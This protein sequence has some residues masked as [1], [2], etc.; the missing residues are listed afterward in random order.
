[1]NNIYV[2]L[3]P[4]FTEYGI[5]I[6]DDRNKLIELFNLE[7]KIDKH[8]PST[9]LSGINKIT[10][11]LDVI[12]YRVIRDN[13]AV[14]FPSLEL[15]TTYG[16]MFQAELYA[17]DYATYDLL[18][19]YVSLDEINLYS[20]SFISSVRKTCTH[21]PHPDAEK[22]D[23]TIFMVM[24]MLEVFKKHGYTL[25][26]LDKTS[27]T[28]TGVKE[29]RRYIRKETITSGTADAF[30]LAVKEYISQNKNDLTKDILKIA[31]KLGDKGGQLK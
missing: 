11:D 25:S 17:L 15:A 26:E 14:I 12:F 4:S 7:C 29:G 20:T 24:E 30:V 13:D 1:M 3:D 21:L 19:T 18:G 6:I 2:G 16:Q 10:K 9:I 8:K 23:I 22:K 28:S 31:P 5:S 27:M